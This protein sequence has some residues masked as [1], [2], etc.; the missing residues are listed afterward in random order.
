MSAGAAAEAT[1]VRVMARFRPLNAS[2]RRRVAAAPAGST[3]AS[4]CVRF[5]D[6]SVV[7][8]VSMY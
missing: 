6:K 5:Q 1:A 4:P 2:E 3:A 7:R 8:H